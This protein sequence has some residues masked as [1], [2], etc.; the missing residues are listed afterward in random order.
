MFYLKVDEDVS[1]HPEK[2]SLISSN[3]EVFVPGGRFREAY[4]WD[5]YWILIG[6]LRSG[7][8]HSAETILL[9]FQTCVQRQITE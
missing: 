5:S 9:N 1:K 2:Y 7:M 4:N 3:R 8:I 6:M